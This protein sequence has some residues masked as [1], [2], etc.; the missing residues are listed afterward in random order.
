[1][2]RETELVRLADELVGEIRAARRDFAGL[3]EAG[4]APVVQDDPVAVAKPQDPVEEAELAV[5][6]MAL[7]GTTREEARA[8][9]LA[10]FGIEDADALL[11]RAPE[12]ASGDERRHTR[13]F[14]RRLRA[15]R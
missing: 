13:R 9:L 2:D 8:H 4:V 15:R 7:A 3:R 5:V 12:W 1:M 11:D 14:A 6:S 10:V